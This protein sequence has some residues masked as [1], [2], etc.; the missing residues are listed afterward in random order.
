[1][2]GES[3]I[4]KTYVDYCLEDEFNFGVYNI[5]KL[6]RGAIDCETIDLDLKKA[7]NLSD[8]FSPSFNSEP[9]ENPFNRNYDL[10]V[11]SGL[12]V[13]KSLSLSSVPVSSLSGLHDLP[14][15]KSYT[16]LYEG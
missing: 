14:S 5:R 4:A 13:L 10:R 12:K 6:Y 7:T 11:L 15:L 8:V 16:Q 3:C 2:V 1:M 9:Y